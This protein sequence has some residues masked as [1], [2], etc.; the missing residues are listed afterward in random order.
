M[1]LLD[2]TDKEIFEKENIGESLLHTQEMIEIS[3]LF[4][5]YRQNVFKH[6]RILLYSCMNISF[7]F[8]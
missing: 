3:K 4:N 1:K 2:K 8:L 6:C 5:M 7:D